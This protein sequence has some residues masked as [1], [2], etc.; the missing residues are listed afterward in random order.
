[1]TFQHFNFLITDSVTRSGDTLLGL[2]VQ[3][4]KVEIIKYF[5]T[6]RG[7]DVNG[8]PLYN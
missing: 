2:A 1:M 5:V 7:V 8:K 4:G 6:E 3:E